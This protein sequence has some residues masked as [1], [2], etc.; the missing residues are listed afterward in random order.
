MASLQFEYA[1]KFE[2]GTEKSLAL[3]LDAKTLLFEAPATSQ[4][5][6]AWAALD[7]C[8]CPHCP[9]EAA[10]RPFCPVAKNLAQA[11][12]AFKEEKSFRKATVFV[13]AK[14]RFY[15]RNTD[16]QVGLQSLFGLIMATSDCPHLE[17]FRPLA[18]FHLPFSTLDETKMRVLGNY[19]IAQYRRQQKGER[20]DWDAKDLH[21]AFQ[22]VN[23]LNQHIIQRIRT[24]SHGDAEQNAIIILDSFA[25]I[26]AGDTNKPAGSLAETGS[27]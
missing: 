27:V 19:L 1:F 6:P 20:A 23:L 24:I 14:E 4:E 25:T 9:Y 8:K 7:A 10:T 12:E 21:A 16:L 26:L 22:N 3:S 15:G 5:P 18:R 17:V 11:A 2:D 13:K